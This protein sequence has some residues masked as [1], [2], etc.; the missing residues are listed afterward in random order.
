MTDT[1]SGGCLCGGVRYRATGPLRPVV[2]CHCV[3][4]RKTS[5]HHA[6]MT[7]V[8]RADLALEADETLVLV[9]IVRDRPARLLPALRRQ[10]LLGAGR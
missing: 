8:P 9:R 1:H 7:S 6:A 4:C 2:A 10:P 3:Q 5:G